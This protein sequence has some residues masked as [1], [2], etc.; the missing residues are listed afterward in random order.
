M[1]SAKIVR[2]SKCLTHLIQ[3]RV[4]VRVWSICVAYGNRLL[5]YPFVCLFPWLA[6]AL[7]APINAKLIVLVYYHLPV[8]AVVYELVP[9][10]VGL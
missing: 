9:Y 10:I 1:L 3:P 2:Q 5:N 6:A 8:M 4:L 7:C